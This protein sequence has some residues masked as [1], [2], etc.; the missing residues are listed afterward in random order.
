M[1]I[2]LAY[3]DASDT[4]GSSLTAILV[5]AF[6]FFVVLVL[7]VIPPLL[8][9]RR[10]HAQLEGLLVAI[11]FWAVA[12]IATLIYTA[13][14]QINWSNERVIRLQSGYGGDHVDASAPT[15]PWLIIGVLGVVYIAL[16]AWASIGK[17]KSE[18]PE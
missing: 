12:T 10:M 3:A 6:L 11:F 4:S 8:A 15:P 16:A 9:R 13:N 18:L 14:A 7:G 5:F 2:W 17:R 1:R